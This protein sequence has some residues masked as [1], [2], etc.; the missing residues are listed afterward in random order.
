MKDRNLNSDG[1]DTSEF[2]FLLDTVGKEGALEVLNKYRVI[3]NERGETLCWVSRYAYHSA[4]MYSGKGE[5]YSF[6][7][8]KEYMKNYI[9]GPQMELPLLRKI[10]VWEKA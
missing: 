6:N 3:S 4:K 10:E 9:E 1:Y 2:D 5:S 7:K 8:W